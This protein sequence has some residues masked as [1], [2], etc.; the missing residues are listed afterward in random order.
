MS[1]WKR[2]VDLETLETTPIWTGIQ[3]HS[4]ILSQIGNILSEKG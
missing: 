1:I 2:I 4:R 3:I